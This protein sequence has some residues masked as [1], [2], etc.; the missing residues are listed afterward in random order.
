[1]SRKMNFKAEDIIHTNIVL[2]FSRVDRF[3]LLLHG[4]A[5]VDIK[6]YCESLPGAVESDSDARVPKV[7]AL[8]RY[9]LLPAQGFAV[10]DPTDTEQVDG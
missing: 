8:L 1:M 4:R 2:K 7:L 10:S 6:T 9:W 5:T 3:R